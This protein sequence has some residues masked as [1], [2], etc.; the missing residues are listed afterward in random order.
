VAAPGRT[1]AVGVT[2][3]SGAIYAMRT[4][5]HLAASADV[6][7]IQLVVTDSGYRVLEEELHVTRRELLPELG[8]RLGDGA[9]R[10]RLFPN[11]DIGAPL[12]SG[13]SAAG[14]MAIIPCSMGTMAAVAAGLSTNLLRRGADVMLK[15]RRPLVLVPREAPYNLLHVE[16]MARLLRAGA[17]VVPASPGFYHHPRTIEDL[18]D[19]VVAKVLDLLG[20]S[21]EIPAAWDPGNAPPPRG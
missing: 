8:R 15:E 4:L 11:G 16:N 13:S 5:H 6:A 12:A 9:A 21:H 20:V 18:V 2:G 1:I 3:A 17:H 14:A 19:H 10:I 7:G